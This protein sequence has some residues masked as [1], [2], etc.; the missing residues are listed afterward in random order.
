MTAV[1]EVMTEQLVTVEPSTSVAAAV[2]V[3]GI[4]RVGAVLE[5]PTLEPA[6][7]ANLPS[8]LVTFIDVATDT[9]PG[10]RPVVEHGMPHTTRDG[11]RFA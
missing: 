6:L 2:T 1:R 11:V 8:P 9:S 4:Q 5:S 3:M 7:L 10:A